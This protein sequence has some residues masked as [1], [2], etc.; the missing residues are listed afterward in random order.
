MR[1]L[2]F[3]VVFMF[4]YSV[5]AWGGR[6]TEWTQRLNNAQLLK[7][8]R[9]QTRTF[10]TLRRQ[11]D[12]LKRQAESVNKHYQDKDYMDMFADMMQVYKTSERL[13]QSAERL[14]KKRGEKYPSY[15]S[16]LI[17][18]G[19]QFDSYSKWSSHA[20]HNIDVAL[21][22]V[23]LSRKHALTRTQ[24]LRNLRAQNK[25]Q[26]SRTALLQV[27]N[28]IAIAGVQ[29][30]MALEEM[31]RQQIDL[32]TEHR[33]LMLAKEEEGER[34]ARLMREEVERGL[35]ELDAWDERAARAARGRRWEAG[36]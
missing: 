31:V 19:Y 29:Q 16:Y 8:V 34:K 11:L 33:A 3:L 23:G 15:N 14:N 32:E 12:L 9:E 26:E 22:G 7:Q 35:R 25:G 1:L 6:A 30:N 27:S 4:S 10:N 21:A 5:V 36:W 20:H 28:D 17:S 18:N 2:L 13:A 24:L